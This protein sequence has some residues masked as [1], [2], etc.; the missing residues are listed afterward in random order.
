MKITPISFFIVLVLGLSLTT[1][2]CMQEKPGITTS[3]PGT[4]DTISQ[5]QYTSNESLV[6][7]VESAA[8]YAETNGKDKALA[9]FNDPNGSFVR[10]ELYIYA[11][12]YNGTTL[13]HPINPETVGLNREGDAGI[14]V[15]EMGAV[16]R[17][18]SGFYRFTY[19]NPKHNRT[20]ES[21]LGYGVQVDEDWWLGSGIYLGPANAATAPA[22][23]PAT[24]ASAASGEMRP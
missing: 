12:D 18:G 1:A 6:A 3:P 23:T 15:R 13:A 7:F 16:V 8:A 2:G 10:G 17:N 14:F 9:E 19:I 5:E 11:Y 21:K 24:P 20:L 4:N 22:T